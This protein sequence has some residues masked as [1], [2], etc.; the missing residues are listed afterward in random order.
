[1]HYFQSSYTEILLEVV[2]GNFDP[3]L[4]LIVLLYLSLEYTC[5]SQ[6]TLRQSVLLFFVSNYWKVFFVLK[7]FYFTES[8]AEK[9]L[10]IIIDNL[11]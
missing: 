3:F 4:F 9:I 1:M 10:L 11:T 8:L 5:T 6:C 2:P 7:L